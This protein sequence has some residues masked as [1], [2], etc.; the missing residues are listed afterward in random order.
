MPLM[1]FPLNYPSQHA[2]FAIISFPH[3]PTIYTLSSQTPLG[4]EMEQCLEV[5]DPPLHFPRQRRRKER[6]LCPT[7]RSACDQLVCPRSQRNQGSGYSLTNY[8]CVWS[9]T[10][11]ESACFL[12]INGKEST[13]PATPQTV[14]LLSKK[15]AEERRALPWP[16][17]RHLRL[18]SSLMDQLC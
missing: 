18:V 8:W 16:M 17:A 1:A 15:E 9:Q 11:Y 12:P 6:P 10:H 7:L 2:A 13:F 5:W 4:D 3:A 14:L